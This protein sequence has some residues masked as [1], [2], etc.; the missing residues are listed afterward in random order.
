MYK[1]WQNFQS[2][3]YSSVQSFKLNQC[4]KPSGT[5]SLTVT[6]EVSHPR[7][8]K[9]GR[10]FTVLVLQLYLKPIIQS[11]QNRQSVHQRFW[12]KVAFGCKIYRLIH[13][14]FV[15]ESTHVLLFPCVSSHWWVHFPR[16]VLFCQPHQQ[17]FTIFLKYLEKRNVLIPYTVCCLKKG[18]S[19]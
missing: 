6:P 11:V 10:T 16:S 2:Y 14:N 3:T 13:N 18:S 4:T 1:T 9:P 8:T 17:L 15:V 7:C 12:Q 19:H 5:F